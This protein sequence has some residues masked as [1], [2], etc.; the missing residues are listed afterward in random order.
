MSETFDIV[1]IGSGSA[2]SI[3]A[4]RLSEDP[5]RSVLLVEAEPDF[6]SDERPDEIRNAYG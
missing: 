5:T 6:G 1:I 3:L 4:A 2:G